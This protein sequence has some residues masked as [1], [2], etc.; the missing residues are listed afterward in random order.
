METLDRL[1]DTVNSGVYFAPGIARAYQSRV[2]DQ[3]ETMALLRYQQYFANRS[4]L[5]IGVG[6]GRTATFLAP[7]AR[8]YVAIDYSAQMVEHVRR[9]QPG[10]EVHLADM[11]DLSHWDDASFDFV[12]AT[13]NVFDAVAHADRLITLQGIRRL[14]TR[15]GLLVFSSHNRRSRDALS[16]PRLQYSRNVV[17]QALHVR[18]YLRRKLNHMRIGALRRFETDYALLND[19]GHDYGLLHYYIDRDVQRRQLESEGFELLEVIDRDGHA[20][21][22]NDDDGANGHLVYVAK[23]A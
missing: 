15:D 19:I 16:G 4:V 8:R 2:L 21:G 5:D 7:L 13:N 17:T 18:T 20:L 3:P 6:T 1:Q 12:F 22:A 11:R 23:R 9:T 10:V 14:L